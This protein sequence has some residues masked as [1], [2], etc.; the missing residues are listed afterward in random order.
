MSQTKRNATRSP[1]SR[2]LLR[3]TVAI[4]LL[5]WF[6]RFAHVRLTT[7]P[8][9]AAQRN[10]TDAGASARLEQ[11]LAR[12]SAATANYVSRAPGAPLGRIGVLDEALRGDWNPAGRADIR[13]AVAVVTAQGV[14]AALDEIA[15]SVAERHAAGR[16]GGALSS[17]SQLGYVSWDQ[18]QIISAFS[19]RA[20]HLHNDKGD[21][22]GALRDLCAGIRVAVGWLSRY[23][24][25]TDRMTAEAEI[26]WLARETPIPRDAG[27]DALALLVEQSEITPS[28]G[29]LR[30]MGFGASAREVLDRFYTDDGDGDGWLALS[31]MGGIMMM[32][33]G[34]PER[35]KGWNLLSPAF[36]GRAAMSAKL[37]AFESEL[38]RIDALPYEQGRTRLSHAT[39]RSLSVADGPFAIVLRQH[40]TWSDHQYATEIMRLI[41]VREALLALA[42]SMYRHDHGEY[43]AS[44]AGLVPSY[45]DDIP[46]EPITARP[47]V[48]ERTSDG[49]FRLSP[50]LPEFRGVSLGNPRTTL[51]PRGA[52]N[53]ARPPH[54]LAP[55]E[56]YSVPPPPATQPSTADEEGGD[57]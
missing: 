15:A 19:V 56:G 16:D 31:E 1:R 21:V 49:G 40:A 54:N 28:E 35:S 23:Y 32:P 4:A 17:L 50:R 18:A 5:L 8:P 36:N 37:T 26:A 10:G 42:L 20:R 11:A 46:I 13:D 3:A 52:Y 53:A 51:S 24:S 41:R 39:E 34:S 30:S 29:L 45:L 7:L 6:A 43:P 48:Y 33:G 25:S 12:F 38:R 47:F 27:G 44:L 57:G 14:D 9:G 22:A 55:D 2:R